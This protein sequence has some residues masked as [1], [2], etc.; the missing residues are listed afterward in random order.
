MMLLRAPSVAALP[1]PLRFCFFLKV[2][3][4]IVGMFLLRIVAPTCKNSVDLDG[5]S[6]NF[7]GPPT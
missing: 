4:E 1:Q 3:W 2:F 7:K 5:D 6:V